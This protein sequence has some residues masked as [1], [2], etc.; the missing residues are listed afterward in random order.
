MSAET[1][2]RGIQRRTVV[3]GVAWSV[4]VIAAAVAVPA[5]AASS[6]PCSIQ[7]DD[8]PVVPILAPSVNNLTSGYEAAR[9]SITIPPG[10]TAVHFELAGGG[11]GNNYYNEIT[12]PTGWGGSGALISGDLR[13]SEGQVLELIV[14]NGGIGP[15]GDSS[16]GLAP[17]NALI[18][19]GGGY[20]AGG[21]MSTG[22]AMYT[23]AGG[24]GGGG[25]AILVG[26]RPLIVA[27]GGGGGGGGTGSTLW[28]TVQ[29]ASG[30]DAGPVAAAGI[31]EVDS[32]GSVTVTT[33]GG[34][35]AAGATPGVRTNSGGSASNGYGTTSYGYSGSAP[36]VSTGGRGGDGRVSEQVLK[37]QY[38]PDKDQF[39]SGAGGGGYAGGAGGDAATMFTRGNGKASGGGGGGGSSFVAAQGVGGV[40]VIGAVT[41]GLAGNGKQTAATRNPGWVKITFLC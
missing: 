11:G 6:N 17:R 33:A 37:D 39:T 7:P 29:D 1:S 5:Q 4:P 8:Q 21:D 24:S 12:A 40:T 16:Q 34:A 18:K 19:G 14:G 3:K 13:V 41:H 31:D 23:Y 22:S 38:G 30:G 27:G 9:G 32:L 15:A 10:V 28:K 35:G 2:A 26:G 25:S 36:I 20:G